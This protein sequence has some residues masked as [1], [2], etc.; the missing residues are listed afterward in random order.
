MKGHHKKDID[1]LFAKTMLLVLLS[2]IA[3][4]A[5][6]YISHRMHSPV[7]EQPQEELGVREARGQWQELQLKTLEDSIHEFEDGY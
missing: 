6:A 4:F 7:E 2:M 3:I 5:I 1:R